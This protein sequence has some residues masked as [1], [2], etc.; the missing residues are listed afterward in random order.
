M[1]AMSTVEQVIEFEK[2]LADNEYF[3][4]VVDWLRY[5]ITS[6]NS[7]TR[8]TEAL[9]AI[10]KPEAIAACGWKGAKGKV[11]LKDCS[12]ICLLFETVGSTTQCTVTHLG[13]KNFLVT[14]FRYGEFYNQIYYYYQTYQKQKT[15][16]FLTCAIFLP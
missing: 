5:H 10:F 14:K 8:M 1:E 16:A 7:T 15:F 2:K 4:H 11:A 9:K 12:K 13:V 6:A 3:K